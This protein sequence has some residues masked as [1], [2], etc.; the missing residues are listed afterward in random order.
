[1]KGTMKIMIATICLAI[2]IVFFILGCYK[3]YS[4]TIQYKAYVTWWQS[5]G[6]FPSDNSIETDAILLF[7]LFV[8]FA[9]GSAY[10]KFVARTK[11]KHQEAPGEDI[12]RIREE[13]RRDATKI[14]KDME[15]PQP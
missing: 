11:K 4:D 14:A 10:Y 3:L 12:D 7:A 13:V 5:M 6:R 2:A 1:M 8:L 9:G 15:K